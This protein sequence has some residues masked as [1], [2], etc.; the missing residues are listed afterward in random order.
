ME[1]NLI[2]SHNIHN[3]SDPTRPHWV[4]T[5]LLWMQ[6]LALWWI[7]I[8]HFEL[9]ADTVFKATTS[10]S[11]RDFIMT[12]GSLFNLK[13]SAREVWE[14]KNCCTRRAFSRNFHFFFR[15][16]IERRVFEHQGVGA[17]RARAIRSTDFSQSRAFEAWNVAPTPLRY[18]RY[19]SVRSLQFEP[20]RKNSKNKSLKKCRQ[21]KNNSQL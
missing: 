19:L 4:R 10:P 21:Q 2:L 18:D 7:K 5:E 6:Y 14:S 17:C 3:E 16:K 9:K 11:L 1:N 15:Y 20:S 8:F 13:H 12:A